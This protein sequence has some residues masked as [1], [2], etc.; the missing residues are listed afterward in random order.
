MTWD[1][2]VQNEGALIAY[3]IPTKSIIIITRLRVVSFDGIH[4]VAT[5]LLILLKSSSLNKKYSIYF[6]VIIINEI[7]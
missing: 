1:Q 6:R 2:F 4:N 5:I 3:V 7:I